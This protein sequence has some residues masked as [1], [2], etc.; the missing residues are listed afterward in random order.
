[1]SALD[2]LVAELKVCLLEQKEIQ[3]KIDSKKSNLLMHLGPNQNYNK[4]GVL[5]TSRSD[6]DYSRINIQK[7]RAELAKYLN[8]EFIEEII[9]LSEVSVDMPGGIIVRLDD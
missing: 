3:N 7:L 4:N 2:I 1:M 9:K 8:S 6:Y 5:I